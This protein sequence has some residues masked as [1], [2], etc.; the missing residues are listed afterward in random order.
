VKIGCGG[1]SA[2]AFVSLAFIGILTGK[3]EKPAQLAQPSPSTPASIPDDVSPDDARL[4]IPKEMLSWSGFKFLFVPSP[5]EV[6]LK[7]SMPTLNLVI[8]S[9]SSPLESM[10]ATDPIWTKVSGHTAYQTQTGDRWV[11]TWNRGNV[12]FRVSVPGDVPMFEESMRLSELVNA[13]AEE[14]Q[15]MSAT[16]RIHAIMAVE[17]AITRKPGP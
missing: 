8:R 14:V 1:K 4:H 9:P 15:G 7:A 17:E 5:G 2:I 10:G 3:R 11:T 16:D 13:R 6:S 12:Q